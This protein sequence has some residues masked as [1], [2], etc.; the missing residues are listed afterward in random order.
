M[1]HPTDVLGAALLTAAW[2]A[3]L[4]FTVRPNAHAE[5]VSE[6]AGEAGQVTRNRR[7]AVVG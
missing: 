5:T 3:V 2:L 4:W 1:H 6:A 7:P